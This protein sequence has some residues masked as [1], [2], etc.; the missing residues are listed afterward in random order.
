MYHLVGN[1]QNKSG[2]A[3]A[4]YFVKLKDAGGAYVTLYSDTSLTPI[5]T[6]SGI[7]N[8]AVT[9]AT[10]LYDL[11]VA[12]GSYDVEFYDKSNSALL[13]SRTP[14]VPMF[15]AGE[16]I[17][18]AAGDYNEGA[19]TGTDDTT[20]FQNNL[21]ALS[22]GRKS[23]LKL[24][25]GRTYLVT[26]Q[27]TPPAG[28]EIDLGG[29][30]VVFKL[31]GATETG[32]QV[33]SNVHIHNGTIKVISLGTPG[34]QAG[35]HGCIRIGPLY[36]SGGT[37]ASP[38]VLDNA[39]GWVLEDLTLYSDKNLGAVATGGAAAISVI[40]N[41]YGGTIRRIRVPGSSTLT[42][43][44]GV[45]WGTRGESSPGV[46]AIVSAPASM[47]TNK[48]NYTGGTG[49]T[50]HP[51]D[52]TISEITIGDL[53]RAYA[54]SATT[55]TFGVRLSGTYGVKVAN[56]TVGSTTEAAF[57]Q[58]AGDLGFEFGLAADKAHALKGNLFENCKWTN[59]STGNGISTDSKADNVQTAI[60]RPYTGSIATTTLT[61]TGAPT[62]TIAVGM[63]VTGLGV[64]ANTTITAL[65]TGTGGTGTYTVNNS[66][67]VASTTLTIGYAYSAIHTWGALWPTDVVFRQ[68]GGPS[69]SGTAIYGF[70][71]YD[72]DGGRFVDCRAEGFLICL[73]FSGARNVIVDGGVFMASRDSVL[74]IEGSSY[75]LILRDV[76]ECHT[77]G[78]TYPVVHI[79][80]ADAVS[81]EGGTYG[82]VSGETGTHTFVASA[83]T[84]TAL[85]FNNVTV[86][87]HGTGSYA[88]A[89]GTGG[90]YDTI[91]LFNGITYG[92]GV[93]NRF[94]GQEYRAFADH[95]NGLI[96]AIGD[97]PPNGAVTA[98]VGAFYTR[99][100]G[101]AGTTLYVKET[102]TNTN[103]GWA[104]K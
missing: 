67:T 33:L 46:E 41:C 13:L 65:G 42:A 79:P 99:T 40:G 20:A 71:C 24:F 44:I 64:A 100:S 51:H 94:V 19:G 70:N 74:R 50:T 68:C 102:G 26:S 88:F 1:F 77:A 93:T 4:G 72:Q 78:A 22:A 82:R 80:S 66:Q 17:D 63:K 69:V 39:S 104:A 37:V 60:G 91:A 95:G 62:S 23:R 6:V 30:T 58:H 54:G 73:R 52:I 84:T 55:G 103:T 34:S 2:D 83:T 76:K 85:R 5:A 98:S 18:G 25:A 7:T 14:S 28:S 49:I 89:V 86:L 43:A 35:I 38:S 10:G 8:T 29:A 32:F 57:T 9:D 81:F 90:V 16:Y 31:S 53:T 3:L 12:E 45:D 96:Y 92:A 75:K 15:G 27:L 36:G 59:I 48:T 97:V 61:I 101:G 21:N 56:V 47:T 87:G 11:Y